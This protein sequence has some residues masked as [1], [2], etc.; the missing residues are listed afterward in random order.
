MAAFKDIKLD[1]KGD[2]FIDPLTGDLAIDYSDQ[3]HIQDIIE[4]TVGS[5]KEFPALGVGIKQYQGSA[6]KE[7]Q[8]QQ[9]ISLQLQ[10]DGYQV[11]QTTVYYNQTGALEID[12]N[13]TR[14]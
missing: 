14:N 6:G 13:A 10:S 1:S 3:N 9:I 4:S 2:L 8:I 12:P 5:W 7:Q 11:G